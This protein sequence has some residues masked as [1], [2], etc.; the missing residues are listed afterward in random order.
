MDFIG[1]LAGFD[2]AGKAVKSVTE[3]LGAVRRLLPADKSQELAAAEQA[4]AQLK[5]ELPALK[6]LAFAL[7]LEN[8]ELKEEN[9]SLK[10]QLADRQQATLQRVGAGAFVYV[11][12]GHAEALKD[13]PWYCQPCF[14][15][16]AKSVLQFAAREFGFDLFK[17]PRCGGQIKVPNSVKAHVRTGSRRRTADLDDF[18]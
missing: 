4:L 16:G 14:D 2:A 15:Q 18:F 9:L 10:Q 7:K 1:A 17:C 8:G 11:L 13:G 5:E 6:D 12:D 3:A